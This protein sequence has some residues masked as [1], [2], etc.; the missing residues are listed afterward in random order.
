MREVK[1]GEGTKEKGRE[2]INIRENGKE[3]K[4]WVTKEKGILKWKINI[5]NKKQEK[6]SLFGGNKEKIKQT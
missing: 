3:V 1:K 4:R 5:N 6:M 2:L